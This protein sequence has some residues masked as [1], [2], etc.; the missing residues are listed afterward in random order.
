MA[1]HEE[2]YAVQDGKL[3]KVR[4]NDQHAFMRHGFQSTKTLVCTVRE[5]EMV[6]ELLNSL[7][8]IRREVTEDVDGLNIEM[9]WGIIYAIRDMVDEVMAKVKGGRH[10]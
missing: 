5:A 6:P 2:W 10:A 7:E 8:L 9:A 1:Q 3:Y 4:E